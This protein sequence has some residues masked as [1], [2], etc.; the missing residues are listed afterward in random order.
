MKV[1]YSR[2]RQLSIMERHP[3][4][5]S[6][7]RF[8]YIELISF[9]Q[10]FKLNPLFSASLLRDKAN[11]LLLRKIYE[12]KNVLAFKLDESDRSVRSSGTPNLAFA[13]HDVR[14]VRGRN[15]LRPQQ[16]KASTSSYF[17]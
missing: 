7:R 17:F 6:K 15:K 4:P 10:G 2:Q 14:E 5:P 1:P 16:S 8:D 9:D 12:G 13:I 3:R 11:F